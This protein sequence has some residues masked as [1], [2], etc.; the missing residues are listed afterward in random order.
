M[1]LDSISISCLGV[2]DSSTYYDS[3]ILYLILVLIRPYNRSNY[4][5]LFFYRLSG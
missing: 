2:Q 3:I 4:L 1:V 5:F